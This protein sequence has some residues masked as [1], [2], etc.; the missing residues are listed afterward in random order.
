MMRD[1]ILVTGFACTVTA[2]FAVAFPVGMLSLGVPLILF[3]LFGL[4][5]SAGKKQ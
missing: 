3:A 2:G 4:E 1:F 5:G